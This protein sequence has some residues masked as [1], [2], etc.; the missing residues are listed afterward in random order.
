MFVYNDEAVKREEDVGGFF[1]FGFYFFLEVFE[2]VGV[3]L[4]GW[5]LPI[6]VLEFCCFVDVLEGFLEV[7]VG[8]GVFFGE[9]L[10]CFVEIVVVDLGE[11]GIV[12]EFF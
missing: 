1:F 8:K 11:P 6:Y 9:V 4:D 2:V 5:V 7:F 10:S 12:F 3:E